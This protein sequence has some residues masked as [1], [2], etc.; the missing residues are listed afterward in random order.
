MADY[1]KMY[2]TLFNKI[3]DIINELQEVQRLTEEMYIEQ[4]NSII[5]LYKSEKENED[6][7]QCP[8]PK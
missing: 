2:H 8:P 1:K 4:D 5:E 3:T 6:S 7:V